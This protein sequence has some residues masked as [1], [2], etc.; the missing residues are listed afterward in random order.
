LDAGPTI[1]LVLHSAEGI[2]AG[3]TKVRYNGVEIGTLTQVRLSDDHKTVVASAQM[4]PKTES[5]LVEGT[6]FWVVR[7]RISG[8][9]VTGLGTLIS[10]AYI[11]LEIGDSAVAK[12]EFVALANEP[13]VGAGSPGRHFV[14]K[15]ADLGSVDNGTPIFYRRLQVGQVASYSL[16]SNGN[17]LTVEIFDNAP[18]DRFVSENTRFWHASGLVVSL[19][20]SGMTVRTESLL[21]ILVGGLAFDSPPSDAPLVEAPAKHSFT[22]FK[23]RESAFN[24]PMQHPI[25]YVLE[26]RQSVRGLARGAPVEFQGVEIGTVTNIDSHLDADTGAVIIPVTVV[27]D[28]TR[29]GFSA[30]NVKPGESELQARKRLLDSLVARGLRAQLKSANFLTGSMMVTIGIMPGAPTEAI[31]WSQDPV[32]IPTAPG[33]FVSLEDDIARIVKKLDALPLEAI[34]QDVKTMI[35][36]LNQTIATTHKT[37]DNF[38]ELIVKKF[39]ALPLE[40]IGEETRKIISDMDLAVQSAQRAIEHISDLARP[41]SVLSGE[42]SGTLQEIARAARN[43]GVLLDYLERHP[44]ALLRGK[45]GESK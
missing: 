28:A 45:S 15:T 11:G 44:E 23:D 30:I 4:A 37:I 9:T 13:V 3:K 36:E 27:V 43:L 16:D 40:S 17:E 42:M 39:G 31:D 20:A 26:F 29:L 21:S 38:D 19:S 32:R 33:A 41:D 6:Q 35:E 8:A 14:L 25:T 2:E 1:S 12:R 24:V 34:G 5:C 22:L 10:G 7:P 18:Y